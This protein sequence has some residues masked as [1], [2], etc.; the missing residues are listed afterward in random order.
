MHSGRDCNRLAKVGFLCLILL[1]FWKA[2]AQTFS[3]SAAL[4]VA[5]DQTGTNV[6]VSYSLTNSQGWVTLF[7]AGSLQDLTTNAQPFDLAP[8]P[9]TGQGQFTSIPVR[10]LV[11]RFSIGIHS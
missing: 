6:I 7:Q 8:A 10:L 9:A 2:G 4:S 11:A 3:N 1:P 5:L